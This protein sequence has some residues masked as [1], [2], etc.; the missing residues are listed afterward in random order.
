MGSDALTPRQEQIKKACSGS[1]PEQAFLLKKRIRLKRYR[2]VVCRKS[3]RKFYVLH[4]DFDLSK[5]YI[6]LHCKRTPKKVEKT[7]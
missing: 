3:G 4:F 5:W 7:A 6:T 1:W 2:G